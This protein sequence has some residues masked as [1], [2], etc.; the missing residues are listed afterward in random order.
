MSEA[1]TQPLALVL[2]DD[3]LWISKITGAG[4]AAGWRIKSVNTPERLLEYAENEPPQLVVLDLGLRG[5]NTADVVSR[6]KAACPA[7]LRFVAYGSH[8]DTATLEAARQAGCDP[9][10]P[11]SKM[12]QEVHTL[13]RE[14]LA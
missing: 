1:T 14:W 12:S 3:F 11:R 6:M 7:G 2:A 4:Q 13:M 8:V 5:L 9:V 10:L